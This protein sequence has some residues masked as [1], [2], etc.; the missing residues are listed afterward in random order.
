MI[1]E[2]GHYTYFSW[3]S[4]ICR[5]RDVDKR[6]KNGLNLK[7]DHYKLGEWNPWLIKKVLSLRSKKGCGF[8]R[9]PFC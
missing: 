4:K 2:A 5:Q 6:W 8:K 1:S 7:L 9:H 3:F